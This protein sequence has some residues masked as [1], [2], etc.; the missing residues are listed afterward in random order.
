MSLKKISKK[1]FFLG[2]YTGCFEGNS[3]AKAI[4][5]VSN[6]K[7]F[8]FKMSSFIKCGFG[9]YILVYYG[10][11]PSDDFIKKEFTNMIERKYKLQEEFD[12]GA[13]LD[14]Y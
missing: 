14:L 6:A 8:L 1:P 11:K 10:K 13:C 5:K 7:T 9:E 12:H 4:E 2:P 3:V